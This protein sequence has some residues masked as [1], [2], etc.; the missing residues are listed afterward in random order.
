MMAGVMAGKSRL[1]TFVHGYNVEEGGQ[2]GFRDALTH[3]DDGFTGAEV[4]Q[5][6]YGFTWKGDPLG[7]PASMP[8]FWWS[9]GNADLAGY[10]FGRY[11]TH[12]RQAAGAGPDLFAITHSL[13]A[14]VALRGLQFL[15]TLRKG[16]G[17]AGTR[18]RIWM[19]STC[20]TPL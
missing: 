20:S 4:P 8:F 3:L 7:R 2:K 14:R 12:T 10:A 13:G 9:E 6:L 11:L 5:D 15:S 16:A 19:G 18:T 1:V 17:N